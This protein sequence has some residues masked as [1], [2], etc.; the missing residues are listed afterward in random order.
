M[1]LPFVSIVD[2]IASLSANSEVE[3][4]LHIPLKPFLKTMTNDPDPSHN[5]IQE[6]YTF[7]Y[8]KKIIW[9]ASARILRQIANRL[10]S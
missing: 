8:Q 3:K 5:K 6:M 10:N 9:G 2:E 4:I 1:I 7:Q